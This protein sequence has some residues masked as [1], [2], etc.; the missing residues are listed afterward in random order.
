MTI[1]NKLI[2]L[3]FA[4]SILGFISSDALAQRGRGGDEGDRGGRWGRGSDD[5][6]GRGGFGRGGFR[7]GGDF[8][9]GGGDR[10]GDRGSDRG[11]DRGGRDSRDRGDDRRREFDPTQFLTRLDANK[12]GTLEPTEMRGR[13]GEF[14]KRL[15][16][17][18]ERPVSIAS[19]SKKVNSDRAARA[20]SERKAEFMEGMSIPGFGEVEEQEGISIPEFGTEGD[21]VVTGNFNFSEDDQQDA[22]RIMRRYDRNDNKVLEKEEWERTRWS[23]PSPEESDTNKDGVLSLNELMYREK[24]RANSSRGGDDNDDRRTRF[25]RDR[26]SNER[27]DRESSN[28]FS[29]DS[30]SRSNPSSSNR[31]SRSNRSPSSS[32]SSS[33]SS[34][35]SANR[36]EQ[37]VSELI[38]Q[39]DKDGDK[40]LDKK[41][42]EAMRRKPPESADKNEDGKL[43]H[44]EMLAYYDRGLSSSKSSSSS[45]GSDRGSSRT[46]NRGGYANRTASKIDVKEYITKDFEDRIRGAGA[47]NKF[48]NL[49]LNKDG[50]VQMH[51]FTEEWD[52]EQLEEFR[53][54][55]LNGDGIITPKEWGQK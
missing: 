9:R 14:V 41:E 35:S 43:S 7:G 42:L 36:M 2:A 48:M 20:E 52:D 22:E 31:F 3:L 40:Q 19:I 10:G 51:E 4:C 13:T 8:G 30:S 37:Y 16:F 23:S 1:S 49:D 28:R 12:N 15:G 46:F 5:N 11:S 6:G 53:E 29:R 54:Y 18:N 38:E 50:Q 27:R 45:R 21:E 55:D 17:S 39:Y 33:S 44:S 34:R 24:L 47:D 32:S 25:S 26:D